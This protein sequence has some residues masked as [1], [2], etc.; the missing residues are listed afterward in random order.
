MTEKLFLRYGFHLGGKA[1][2]WRPILNNFLAG[3]QNNVFLFDLNKT[4]FSFFKALE[5]IK[6]TW[7]EGNTFIFVEKSNIKGLFFSVYKFPTNLLID[8]FFFINRWYGGFFSNFFNLFPKF[9]DKIR[10]ININQIIEKK[11]SFQLL[12]IFPKYR[13]YWQCIS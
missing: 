3:K 13:C 4:R 6:R 5:F 9:L 12:N 11:L 7:L 2:L 1:A 8:R 10:N